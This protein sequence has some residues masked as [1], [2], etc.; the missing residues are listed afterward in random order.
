MF[1]APHYWGF[2]GLISNQN[3]QLGGTM[4]RD[5]DHDA[6][7]KVRGPNFDAFQRRM[8][9]LVDHVGSIAEIARKCGIPASTVKKWV[10]G[11]SDPSRERCVALASGTGASLVWIVS[12]EGPMLVA[13]DGGSDGVSEGAQPPYDA[14]AAQALDPD[15]LADAIGMIESP[16]IARRGLTLESRARL[17]VLAYNALVNPDVGDNLRLFVAALTKLPAPPSNES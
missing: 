17:M 7:V 4:T 9:A 16:P 8:V 14:A 10:D 3:N 11:I 2:V 15:R 13:R 12:G 6:G 5:D 1:E